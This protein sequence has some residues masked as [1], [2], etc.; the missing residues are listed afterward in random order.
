MLKKSFAMF[1]VLLLC[2]ACAKLDKKFGS[3]TPDRDS[4]YLNQHE[5]AALKLPPGASLNGKY[6][7]DYFPLPRGTRPAPGTEPVSI[8]PPTLATAQG[9]PIDG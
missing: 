8:T 1:A 3:F 6:T 7:T 5:V 9:E 2:N 4:A